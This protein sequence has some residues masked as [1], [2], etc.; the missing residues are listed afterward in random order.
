[1]KKKIVIKISMNGDGDKTRSKALQI[2]V[3]MSGVESASL[4]DK[5]KEQIEVV[6]EGI[7]AVKLTHSLRNKLIKWPFLA[8][9]LPK[10]KMAY[11]ELVSV[12]D[13]PDNKEANNNNSNTNNDIVWQYPPPLPQYVF[14][15]Q[16]S[17]CSIF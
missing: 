13:H 2:A 9:F 3:S 6:G 14:Y 8:C 4:V 10:S 1:M 5:D 12:A 15:E 7:D 16:P 17:R 11:A